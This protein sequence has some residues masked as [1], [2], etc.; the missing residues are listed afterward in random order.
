MQPALARR[1]ESLAEGRGATVMI[2]CTSLGVVGDTGRPHRDGR[3]SLGTAHDWS[4]DIVGAVERPCTLSLDELLALPAKELDVDILC[5]SRGRI[6]EPAWGKAVARFRGVPL[7]EIIALAGPRPDVQTVRFISRAPGACGPVGEL[8][9]TTLDFASCQLPDEVLLTNSFDGHPLP[10]CNGG[11]LRSIARSR[12]FYKSIKWLGAIEFL[13]VEPGACRGTWERHAGYH[14]VGLKGGPRFEPFLKLTT[15]NL[16]LEEVPEGHRRAVLASTLA[17][18]DVSRVVAALLHQTVEGF[19]GYAG[20]NA[21]LVFTREFDGVALPYDER[22]APRYRAALR[23]TLF[24]HQDLSGWKLSHVNFSLSYFMGANLAGADLRYCDF[25][26]ARLWGADLRG[27]DL[28]GAYLGA[29]E[30]FNVR[31]GP[32]ASPAMVEGLDVTG[33]R[34]LS[35]ATTRWLRERGASVGGLSATDEEDGPEQGA[36]CC[37]AAVSGA[38]GWG[39]PEGPGGRPS[40]G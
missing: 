33:A 22:G 14:N 17:Q 13:P 4:V 21:G 1:L 3:A 19:E 12:Y 23:G 28:R 8:H 16:G 27:A 15:D 39:P 36:A 2:R 5:V 32:S 11:P 18:G 31:R 24:S 10:Y 37:G 6:C 34:G 38:C 20:W 9:D 35:A 40:G 30:F 26:G 7:A 29:A 25:E